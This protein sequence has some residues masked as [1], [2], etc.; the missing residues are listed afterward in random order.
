MLS[1]VGDQGLFQSSVTLMSHLNVHDKTVSLPLQLPPSDFQPQSFC[2]GKTKQI[3]QTARAILI[4][5]QVSRD[6]GKPARLP[7][8]VLADHVVWWIDPGVR[9]PGESGVAGVRWKEE[10]AGC[11]C[12]S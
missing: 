6:V 10:A 5:V 2:G 8:H 3:S 1:G 11:L 9:D 4:M 7:E 12:I